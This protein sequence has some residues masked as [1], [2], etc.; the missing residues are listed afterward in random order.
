MEDH[1][2]DIADGEQRSHRLNRDQ[3]E[4]I[5]DSSGFDVRSDIAIS[6]LNEKYKKKPV[7]VANRTKC[8]VTE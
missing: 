8:F 3:K 6:T 5:L 2:I 7:S 4:T 1:I